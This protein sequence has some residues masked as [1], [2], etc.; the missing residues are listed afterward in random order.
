MS[1][2]ESGLGY[3]LNTS[4]QLDPTTMMNAS[5]GLGADDGMTLHAAKFVRGGQGRVRGEVMHTRRVCES[6]RS[7]GRLRRVFPRS[8]WFSGSGGSSKSLAGSS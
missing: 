8:R 3:K 4:K 2:Q 6:C 5:Y 1:H 7:S